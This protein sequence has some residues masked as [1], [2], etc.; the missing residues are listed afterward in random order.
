MKGSIAIAK[1]IIATIV[2][3]NGRFWNENWNNSDTT[4]KISAIVNK[5]NFRL[6]LSIFLHHPHPRMCL[7]LPD[8]PLD[9]FIILEALVYFLNDR[10]VLFLHQAYQHNC[11]QLSTEHYSSFFSLTF[12]E[13]TSL[14]KYYIVCCKSI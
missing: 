11:P 9:F 2:A 10:H 1:G 13:N 3:E 4:Q 5:I 8:A 12:K 14:I 6:L 7:G